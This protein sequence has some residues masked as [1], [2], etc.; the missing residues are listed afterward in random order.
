MPLKTSLACF[1]TK[2]FLTVSLQCL[3]YL[4]TKFHLLIKHNWAP[5]Q[6]DEQSPFCCPIQK[7]GLVWVMVSVSICFLGP[8]GWMLEQD[9]RGATWSVSHS[10]GPLTGPL[11]ALE[12]MFSDYECETYTSTSHQQE[13]SSWSLVTWAISHNIVPSSDNLSP[14]PAQILN[15]QSWY[16][17]FKNLWWL[18]I[19]YIL[20]LKMLKRL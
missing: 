18:L 2:C 12:P 17:F 8:E 9:S 14:N 6:K 4:D 15:Y 7:L 13:E 1:Y 20:L 3:S 11:Q 19:A 5:F 16:S 10:V